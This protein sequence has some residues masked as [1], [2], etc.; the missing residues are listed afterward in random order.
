M[1]DVNINEVQSQSVGSAAD[2]IANGGDSLSQ[3]EFF[4]ASDYLS[5]LDSQIALYKDEL[6]NSELAKSEYMTNEALI[7][8]FLSKTEIET[9]SG[10][11]CVE[12]DT[13]EAKELVEIL[14]S[15]G[16]KMAA[17]DL[18]DEISDVENSRDSVVDS[19]QFSKKDLEDLK[20]TYSNKIDDLNSSSELKMIRF[21]TLTD[22][23]KQA[24]LM[25]SNMISSD[26]STKLAII[27]NLKS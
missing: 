9:D 8:G 7:S 4:I 11:A 16:Q 19:I 23:R 25:L 18:E 3:V 22:A 13:G 2:D 17:E 10:E 6:E 26:N 1:T 12:L 14:K 20:T 27:Q 5:G 15:L 24:L 21:Q